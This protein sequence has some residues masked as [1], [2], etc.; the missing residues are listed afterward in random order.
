MKPK[1][2]VSGTDL[3]KEL[4]VNP[5][6]NLRGPDGNRAWDSQGNISPSSGSRFLELADIALGIRK[7]TPA[8][9]KKAAGAA[10]GSQETTEKTEPYST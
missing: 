8:K 10:A 1:P 9:K 5:R 2:T 6:T 7:P 4:W 3:E